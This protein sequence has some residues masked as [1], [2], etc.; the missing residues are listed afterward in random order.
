M[1]TGIAF[2]RVDTL[3]TTGTAGHIYFVK[4]TSEIYV[5]TGSGFEKYSQPI[6]IIDLTA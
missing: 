3:P 4:S 2:H 1:S 5:F 6:N